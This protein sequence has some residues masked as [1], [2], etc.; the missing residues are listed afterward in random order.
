MVIICCLGVPLNSSFILCSRIHT[1]I[2]MKKKKE[3]VTI[4]IRGVNGRKKDQ[5]PVFVF[6][7]GATTTSPDA[8]YGWVKSTIFVLFVTMAMSPTAPSKSYI[9]KTKELS[10]YIKS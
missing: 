1:T 9:K 4:H 2:P 8:A 3:A 7:K 5:P 10:I 6:L